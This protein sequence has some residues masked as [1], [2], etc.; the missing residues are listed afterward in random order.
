M[1]RPPPDEQ[2]E[3]CIRRVPNIRRLVCGLIS[4]TFLS[5]LVHI[6]GTCSSLVPNSHLC[7][8]I[9]HNW[10]L[11]ALARIVK[12][13][14]RR[15]W[16]TV[17]PM[18][19]TKTNPSSLLHSDNLI[20]AGRET[21]RERRRTLQSIRELSSQNGSLAEWRAPSFENHIA[22]QVGSSCSV[23]S[24]AEFTDMTLI[25]TQIQQT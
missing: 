1:T 8:P 15:T 3:L 19:L 14:A 6:V 16:R 24:F 7:L 10:A 21:L 5:A 22:Y 23:P 17:L 2:S 12:Y 13:Q 4:F 18:L 11:V 25:R 9:L 20:I